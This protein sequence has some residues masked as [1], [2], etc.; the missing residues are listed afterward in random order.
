MKCG[1][2]ELLLKKERR[3]LKVM[4]DSRLFH[5]QPLSD[6]CLRFHFEKQMN[7]CMIFPI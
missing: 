7:I 6:N 2:K 4:P 5:I 3:L 1:R